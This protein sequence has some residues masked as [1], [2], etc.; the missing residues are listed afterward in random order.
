MSYKLLFIS[1]V[2][3]NTGAPLVLM[4][5]INVCLS[6]GHKVDVISLEDG[7]LSEILFEKGISVTI[8][9]NFLDEIEMWQIIFKKYDAVIANTMLCI[10][11]VYVLNITNVATIWWIHEHE[12]WFEAY[13]TI[14]PKK[15]DLKG[16]IKVYGVSPHTNELIVRYCGYKTGLLPFG[17]EDRLGEFETG[18]REDDSKVRFILSGTYSPVKGQDILCEAVRLLPQEIREKCQFTM[19]GSQ[20]D[21]AIGYYLGLEEAAREM[22]EIEVLGTLSHDEVLSRMAES[23]YV[24]APSRMEPFSA[25]AVEGMMLGAVPVVSDV[26]G[27][28]YWLRSGENSYIF[29]SED[30]MALKETIET[31]VRKRLEDKESYMNMKKSARRLFEDNFSKEVFRERFLGVI[32]PIFSPE[33]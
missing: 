30:K 10:D 4:D 12:S 7:A 8:A 25:T 31:A 23:D 11:A 26:C 19:C 15:E 27:V 16:N 21:T 24:L 13:Q 1:H 14:L 6:Q 9:D 33:R 29:S 5:A 17:I 18:K 2:L 3:D 28:T 22:N 32:N 20:V